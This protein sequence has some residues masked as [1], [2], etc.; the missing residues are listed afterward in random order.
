MAPGFY[1]TIWGRNMMRFGLA[2]F[3]LIT[4][5]ATALFGQSNPVPFVNQPL[6]PTTVAPGSSGFTL[7]V[8]GTGFVSG[9]VVN[10][11]GSPRATTFVSASKLK[12]AIPAADIA[13]NGTATVTVVNPAPG[14]GTSNRAFV[15]G[16]SP[17]TGDCPSSVAVGDFNGDGILD[18]AVANDCSNTIS[19]LLGDG[20]G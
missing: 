17:A 4:L 3:T 10:W 12:A 20:T 19:M 9:S 14:G 13:T 15:P 1:F 18:L 5:L 8:N 16:S 2:A 11:N 6:V 7:T